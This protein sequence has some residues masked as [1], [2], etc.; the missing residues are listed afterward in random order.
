MGKGSRC[1]SPLPLLF[2]LPHRGPS[3]EHHGHGCGVVVHYCRIAVW[4][5]IALGVN[6]LDLARWWVISL[7]SHSS[8]SPFVDGWLGQPGHLPCPSWPRA[9]GGAALP[10]HRHASSEGILKVW[11]VVGCGLVTPTEVDAVPS[12]TAAT[13]WPRISANR[14]RDRGS[15]QVLAQK[16]RRLGR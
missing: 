1:P 5:W 14:R 9:L 3:G 2:D 4:R 11:R 13:T 15:C 16:R 12:V 6:P 7:V 10:R 8:I